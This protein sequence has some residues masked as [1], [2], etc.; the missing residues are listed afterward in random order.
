MFYLGYRDMYIVEFFRVYKKITK[1]LKEI[2]KKQVMSENITIRDLSYWKEQYI[3]DKKEEKSLSSEQRQEVEELVY[4]ER[5]ETLKNFRRPI[6]YD[7][8]GKRPRWTIM[9]AALL[10][11]N[12]CPKDI[13]YKKWR[14][15][16]N[17]LKQSEAEQY[18]KSEKNL[19]LID[20]YYDCQYLKSYNKQ[21]E[22]GWDYEVLEIVFSPFDIIEWVEKFDIETPEELINAVKDTFNKEKNNSISL[23]EKYKQLQD[24]VKFLEQQLANKSKLQPTLKELEDTE[25]ILDVKTKRT[26]DRVLAAVALCLVK[27]MND[28][29]GTRIESIINS[30]S[31]QQLAELDKQ[32]LS[33]P[34]RKTLTKYLKTPRKLIGLEE[35]ASLNK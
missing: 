8:W 30:F 31:T 15:I 2:N 34:N 13:T 6:A 11:S 27:P 14:D 18:L 23:Q 33:L 19:I 35:I 29:N 17:Y 3:R 32:G 22:C 16:K 24:R 26:Y 10:I 4:K 1:C 20:D 9:E 28:L 21:I 12:I 25:T 7:F 5:E